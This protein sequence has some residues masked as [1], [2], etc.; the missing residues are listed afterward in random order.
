[1]VKRDAR[2]HN[3]VVKVAFFEPMNANGCGY[4][5]KALVAQSRQSN[6]QVL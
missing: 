5:Q 1:M 2:G 3:I 4:E 6:V